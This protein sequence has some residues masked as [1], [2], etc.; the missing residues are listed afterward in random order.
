MKKLRPNA[1]CQVGNTIKVTDGPFC[2]YPA[3]IS[4]I[5][6]VKVDGG[7]KVKALLLGFGRSTPVE[8]K[9]DQFEVVAVDNQTNRR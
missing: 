8:L 2:G 6:K 5:G 7:Y 4:E 1:K 3:V 9:H